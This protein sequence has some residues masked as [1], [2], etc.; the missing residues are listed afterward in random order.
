M[1]EPT[2]C[3]EWISGSFIIP[4]KDSHICWISDFRALNKALRR[5]VYPIPRIQEILTR[6]TGYAFLPKL[7]ILM[8]YYTFELDD[9]SKDLCTIATPFGLYHYCC[10]P[11]GINQSPDIAQ[12]IMECVL[13]SIDDIEIYIDDIACF[14]NDFDS[15]MALL[16]QVFAHLQDHGF[17]T[18]HSNV[19]GP[20]K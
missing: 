3:S 18:T 20:S 1:L 8:Q 10:L 15:H 14:S 9:A 17:A 19:N 4:K 13:H 5:N 6:Q 16:D 2:S 7:D 12:E 11:M